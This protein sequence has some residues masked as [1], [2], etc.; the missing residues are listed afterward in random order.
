MA[1]GLARN[2][3]DPRN[4]SSKSEQPP[5]IGITA[6]VTYSQRSV[7]RK[8]ENLGA[9]LRRPEPSQRNLFAQSRLLLPLPGRTFCMIRRRQ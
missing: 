5:S 2:S 9:I 3:K 1:Q 7:A 8:L 4:G 6:P